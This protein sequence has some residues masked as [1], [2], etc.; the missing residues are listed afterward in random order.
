M[1]TNID[2]NNAIQTIATFLRQ[3]P[4]CKDIAAE[5]I[6]AVLDIVMRNN[7]FR[8]GDT[9]WI[10]KTGTAMG[11]PP[12][13]CMTHSTMASMSYSFAP[14][15][16]HFYSIFDGYGSWTVMLILMH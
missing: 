14:N 5:P 15:S 16:S 7:L 3:A 10:Q 13:Q 12:A 8:F 6:I 2:M 4:L 11:T 9:Y 1:Y